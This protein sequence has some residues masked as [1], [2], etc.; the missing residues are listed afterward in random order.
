MAELA[1]YKRITLEDLYSRIKAGTV[2]ELGI[3]IKGDVQG[4]V[5]P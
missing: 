3:I 2:K 5:K 4:S 1:Q